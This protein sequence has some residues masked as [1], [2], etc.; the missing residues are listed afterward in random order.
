MKVLIGSLAARVQRLS[1]LTVSGIG[2]GYVLGVCLAAYSTPVGTSFALFYIL[3]I[4]FVAWG[5][6][7]W[8]GMLVGLA[9]AG[10]VSGWEWFVVRPTPGSSMLVWNGLTRLALYLG[11]AWLVGGGDAAGSAPGQ[12]GGG[13]ERRSGRRRRRS[14]RQRRA[15]WLRRL[16]VSSRCIN[17]LAEVFW[18]TDVAKNQMV[19]ISPGY[20]RIWGRTRGA[21]S[22]AEVV[23]GG[24]ASGRIVRR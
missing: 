7:R 11:T 21:V 17:N 9:G 3:G 10:L 15:G 24:S 5:A 8:Q 23:A 18:L 22:G 12:T 16:S 20:E 2:L 4:A 13:N 1:P 14:T 6:G 19:Y